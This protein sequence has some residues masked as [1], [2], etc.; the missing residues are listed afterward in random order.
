M[1]E[2][3]RPANSVCHRRTIGRVSAG[4]RS[5]P[6]HDGSY[7]GDN[8]GQQ[9]L[10]RPSRAPPS[11]QPTTGDAGSGLRGRTVLPM[12]AGGSP[13]SRPGPPPGAPKSAKYL[14]VDQVGGHGIRNRRSSAQRLPQDL[15]LRYP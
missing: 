1:T 15:Q 12:L 4:L 5:S 2:R 14:P 6:A 11:G 7:Q 8:G 9:V 13:T 3:L 10:P